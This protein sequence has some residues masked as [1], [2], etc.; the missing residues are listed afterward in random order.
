MVVVLVELSN[1][2]L[3]RAGLRPAAEHQ[4][5]RP[6]GAMSGPAE[7]REARFRPGSR[8]TLNSRSPGGAS[9]TVFEDDGDTGYFYALDVAREHG[10]KIV[11]AIH[12][13]TTTEDFGDDHRDPILARI[14][15]SDDGKRS[16]LEIDGRLHAVFDFSKLVGCGLIGFPPASNGWARKVVDE[17]TL[18]RLFMR[19]AV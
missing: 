13:Y 12:I 7:D 17:L 5:V 18:Q 14:V 8:E 3:Q 16:G 11:D 6:T 4:I 19:G 1:K 15:W 9:M 10:E 2:L